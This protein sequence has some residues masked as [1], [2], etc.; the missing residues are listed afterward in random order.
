MLGRH[1]F[2]RW[3]HLNKLKFMERALNNAPSHLGETMKNT[4]IHL[5]L[6]LVLLVTPLCASATEQW[7]LVKTI[8][9]DRDDYIVFGLADAE[10]TDSKDI[11]L[12]NAKANYVAHYDW[13]GNFKRRIGHRGQGPGDFSFPWG[14]AYYG[15][16]LYVNDRGNRRIVGI[17]LDTGKFLFFKQ[18]PQNA[19]GRVIERLGKDTFLGT[20]EGI[21]DKRGRIGVF[22]SEFNPIHTFFNH[23]PVDIGF[24]DKELTDS[25]KDEL[26]IRQALISS[27]THPIFALDRDEGEILTSFSS[28]DNP[29]LFYIYNT[30]G[31]FLRKFSYSIDD[32]RC[33]FPKFLLTAPLTMLAQR[34]KYPDRC[35]PDLSL[36]AVLK[37]YYVVFLSLDDYAKYDIAKSRKFCLIFNRDGKLKERFPLKNGVRIF[38]YSNGYFLGSIKDADEEKLYIYKL[39]I[40]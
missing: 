1:E 35:S 3:R 9:D 26:M 29:I 18:D 39:N 28:P 30:A 11:Y 40:K 37:D 19:L 5:I 31:K 13:E 23:Y 7:Q 14:L 21:R 38:K 17:N 27:Y 15:K 34:D 32:K 8:G 20:F 12:L 10:I 16:N 36:I 22:D 4:M 2:I 33:K 24:S 6:T 25:R